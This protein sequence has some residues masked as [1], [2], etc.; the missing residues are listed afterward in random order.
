[1]S[2]VG[3]RNLLEGAYGACS[4]VWKSSRSMQRHFLTAL[5]TV[6]IKAVA[7]ESGLQLHRVDTFQHWTAPEYINLIVAVSFGLLVPSRI[8]N[9]T[10][11]GG[12]NVHPSLLP[13]LRGAAPI[14][15]A[16]LNRRTHTGVSLQTMHPSKFDHG[17]VLDQTPLPGIPVP[18]DATPDS[19]VHAL[20]PIGAD[21]LSRGIDEGLFLPPLNSVAVE[22]KSDVQLAPKITPSD[23]RIQWEAWSADEILIRDRALGSLWDL[24]TYQ[25]C[26]PGSDAKRVTFHGPW[27]KLSNGSPG[28]ANTSTRCSPVLSPFQKG[29]GLGI[30]TADLQTMVPHA[31]TIEGR[32]KGK[33]LQILIE[34]LRDKRQ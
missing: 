8:L 31:A 15:R 28:S 24:E 1:M 12:L 23:R 27:A 7:E 6:P 14:M 9:A 19:L 18:G 30:R 10:H 11:Y 26:L 34:K 29:W 22:P 2:F 25:A 13:D 33:G 3:P 16:L 4:L 21:M 20:G 32:P 17:I 5:I